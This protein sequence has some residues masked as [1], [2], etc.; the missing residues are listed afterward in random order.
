MASPSTGGV[1]ASSSFWCLA[2]SRL[3][4]TRG[5]EAIVAT[6]P[7]CGSTTRTALEGIVEFVDT[8]TFLYGCH[9]EGPRRP[10]AATATGGADSATRLQAVTAGDAG[11]TCAVCLDEIEPGTS[12]LVTPCEH[13]YH[14]RCIT[15]WLEVNDTC[16]LCRRRSTVHVEGDDD[17]ASAPDGLVLCNLRNGQLGLGRRVAGR[18]FDVRILYKDGKLVRQGGARRLFAAVYHRFKAAGNSLRS[19][20][21]VSSLS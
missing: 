2:C 20:N 5:G 7:G 9:P 18:V 6:Y 4:R 21:S 17:V 3:H 15:P 14:P 11:R 12:A 1:D 8:R 10:S 19:R 13:K 16:P